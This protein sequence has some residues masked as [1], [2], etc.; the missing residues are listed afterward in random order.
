MNSLVH[1]ESDVVH[2]DIRMGE[3]DQN[4]GSPSATLNS[5]SPASTAATRS[6]SSASTTALHTC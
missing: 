5:Q 3:V 2:D 6:R 4:L 1:G